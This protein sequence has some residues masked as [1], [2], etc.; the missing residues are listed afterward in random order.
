[1]EVCAVAEGEFALSVAKNA[2]MQLRRPRLSNHMDVA[3]ESICDLCRSI[4][5]LQSANA[6]SVPS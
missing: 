2:M 3:L 4:A 5:P 6:E 1:M